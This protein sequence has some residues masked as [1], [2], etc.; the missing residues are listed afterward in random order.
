M[1]N[2]KKYTKNSGVGKNGTLR[3]ENFH[4]SQE[5]GW[6]CKLSEVDHGGSV[7]TLRDELGILRN[8]IASDVF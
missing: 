7:V 1:S 3:M 2:L 4:P 6:E 8:C 5:K